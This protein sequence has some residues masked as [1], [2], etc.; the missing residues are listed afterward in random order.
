MTDSDDTV[1]GNDKQNYGLFEL[2]SSL[3]KYNIYTTF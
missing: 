3:A 2:L 1:N